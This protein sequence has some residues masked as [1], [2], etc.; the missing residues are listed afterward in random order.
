MC[1][2]PKSDVGAGAG[3]IGSGVRCAGQGTEQCWTERG[4]ERKSEGRPSF[5]KPDAVVRECVAVEV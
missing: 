1:C 2:I 5:Q 3:T 4:A